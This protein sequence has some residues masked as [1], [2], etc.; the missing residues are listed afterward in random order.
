MFRVLFQKNYEN[1]LIHELDFLKKMRYNKNMK[2][3]IKFFIWQIY[4]KF[5]KWRLRRRSSLTD[6][7]LYAT[8]YIIDKYLLQTKPND[9]FEEYEQP[10]D[11]ALKRLEKIDIFQKLNIEP[12]RIDGAFYAICLFLL[13]A[14]DEMREK[15][16]EHCGDWPHVEKLKEYIKSGV[17]I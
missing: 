9:Y 13:V 10:V 4:M 12:N 3:K 1:G 7:G 15:I 2:K 11:S 14:S 5:Y 16:Y 6:K 17:I 8:Y